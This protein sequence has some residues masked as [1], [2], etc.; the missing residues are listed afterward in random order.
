[1]EWVEKLNQS[2]DYIEENLT[3]ELD[4]EQLARVACCSSYHFQRMFT[5]MAGMTLS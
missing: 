5:Y 1:M 3:K 2:M 4:Y